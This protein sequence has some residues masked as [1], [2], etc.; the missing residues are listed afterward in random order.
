MSTQS[1]RDIVSV[2]P[3]KI[4]LFSGNVIE[5]I[6]VGEFDPDME[7]IITICKK[8]GILAFIEGLPNGFETHLGENGATLSGGQKQMVALARALYQKPQLLLLD[9]PT[10]AM[11]RETEKKVLDLLKKLRKE[12]AVI[13][14]THRVQSIK[15]A[16]RI[17]I[18][19]KGEIS[20]SGTP[21]S[22]MEAE[23]LF[24]GAVQDV[25]V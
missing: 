21:Q 15:H 14:V 7:K 20:T 5:N 12:M 18:L 25:Y 17:Y 10:S 3:Q 19:E 2:V 1:L 24:S 23:N 16:E 13:M 8:L 6:A 4:D 9:E 11:D 22:L